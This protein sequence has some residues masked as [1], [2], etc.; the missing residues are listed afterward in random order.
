MYEIH[1]SVANIN[2]EGQTFEDLCTKIP[3]VGLFHRSRHRRE[4]T[5]AVAIPM[6]ALS[7]DQI[8]ETNK[9]INVISTSSVSYTNSLL[10]SS[11]HISNSVSPT[12]DVYQEMLDETID[13]NQ[14][15][16]AHAE[17]AS[18]GISFLKADEN[19]NISPMEEGLQNDGTEQSIANI[20]QNIYCENIKSLKEKCLQ[21]SL[22]EIWH[23]DRYVMYIHCI[24][25][26]LEPFNANCKF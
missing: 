25:H 14:E 23:Y 26:V 1:A 19:E 6:A 4:N 12:L 9:N 2:V 16:F 22:L 21:L 11:N 24:C 15:A 7:D 10:G 5:E 13:D 8:S 20:P 17:L 18:Q 3:V